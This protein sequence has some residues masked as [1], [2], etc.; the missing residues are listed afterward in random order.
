MK[1]GI[2]ERGPGFRFSELKAAVMQE[3][4]VG[5]LPVFS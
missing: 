5:F 3:I 1:T 2:P 4:T